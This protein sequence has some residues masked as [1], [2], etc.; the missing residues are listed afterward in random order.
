MSLI[1][2][3]PYTIIEATATI[4]VAG[5]VDLTVGNY[6]TLTDT[7]GS[8]VQFAFQNN[9]TYD[10]TK[11]SGDLII[12]IAAVNGSND[13]VADRIRT[14]INIQ[15]DVDIAASGSGAVVNLTQ[16]AAG[17]T[18]NTAITSTPAGNVSYTNFSGGT[19]PTAIATLENP[20]RANVRQSDDDIKVYRSRSGSPYSY[21]NRGV[22]YTLEYSV[23]VDTRASHDD[24]INLLRTAAQEEIKVTDHNSQVWRVRN[25]K[26][27]IEFIEVGLPQGTCDEI[28]TTTFRF[29]GLKI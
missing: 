18:G 10:G 21:V 25:V 29:R 6:F 24:I 2:A 15:T 26:S 4:T 19:S 20:Q 7:S 17:A 8:S 3:Y 16:D 14:V 11:Y 12:G 28:T 5:S 23:P 27:S 1:L 13:D 9:N 22:L